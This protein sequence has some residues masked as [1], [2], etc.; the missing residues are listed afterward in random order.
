M[1]NSNAYLLDPGVAFC[2]AELKKASLKNSR[3]PQKTTLALF[4]AW[5]PAMSNVFLPTAWGYLRKKNTFDKNNL[6]NVKMWWLQNKD[7]YAG[8]VTWEI[9]LSGK[10]E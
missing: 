7:I 1:L 10:K 8:Y 4:L 3:D 6:N 5:S 9:G 2:T